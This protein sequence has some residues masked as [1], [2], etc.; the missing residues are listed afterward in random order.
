MEHNTRNEVSAKEA[1]GTSGPAVGERCLPQVSKSTHA[2]QSAGTSKAPAANTG[3]G[4]AT[5]GGSGTQAFSG[6]RKATDITVSATH[7]VLDTDSP[8][9]NMG[10]TPS[11]TERSDS[12]SV[13]SKLLASKR[14][15]PNTS[16]ANNFAQVIGKSKK[17]LKAQNQII[18][19]LCAEVDTMDGIKSV[20]KSDRV[21][22]CIASVKEVTEELSV[23][24]G[25]LHAALNEA[26]ML[27]L[28]VLPATIETNLLERESYPNANCG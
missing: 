8:K 16:S 14:D 3:V 27:V 10:H 9:T 2:T 17:M 18:N 20:T 28:Q 15:T 1:S 7:G 6:G 25:P 13:K 22:G 24:R 12:S 11:Q 19:K 21:K 4:K 23:N 5:A 26:C